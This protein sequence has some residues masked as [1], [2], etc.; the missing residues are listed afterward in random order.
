MSLGSG[1]KS[2]GAS[3]YCPFAMNDLKPIASPG[4]LTSPTRKVV[5]FFMPK[6]DSVSTVS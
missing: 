5:D 3:T 6:R 2:N 4:G 1:G